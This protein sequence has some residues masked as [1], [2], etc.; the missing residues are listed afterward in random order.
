M[1]YLKI[2][3]LLLNSGLCHQFASYGIKNREE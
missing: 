3:N 2:N 1:A